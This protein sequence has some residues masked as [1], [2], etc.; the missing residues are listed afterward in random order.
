LALVE[1][2]KDEPGAADIKGM[3]FRRKHV[4]T[5]TRT[6]TQAGQDAVACLQ[7]SHYCEHGDTRSTCKKLHVG[8][9]A[10]VRW[11]R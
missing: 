8:G 9:H 1:P 10:A 7:S 3:I 2:I 4:P 5:T 6:S 11:V